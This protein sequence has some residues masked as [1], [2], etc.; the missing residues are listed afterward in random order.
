MTWQC[1]YWCQCEH[2]TKVMEWLHDEWCYPFQEIGLS[3][4]CQTLSPY[5]ETMK[6]IRCKFEFSLID[7]ANLSL[8]GARSALVPQTSQMW[9]VGY[10]HWCDCQWGQPVNELNHAIILK[11]N[12]YALCFCWWCLH[13]YLI[14]Y[15]CHNGVTD[16]TL[17]WCE[18]WLVWWSHHIM[19]CVY[20]GA[21]S[22]IR[23]MSG[24]Q[25][26]ALGAHT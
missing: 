25:D 18:H 6:M 3:D 15:T 12:A 19:Y 7:S 26:Q 22:N 10:P 23:N 4:Q 21:Q 1:G 5:N 9:P 2:Y 11:Y 13:L 17:A 8:R 14:I 20:T 24:R 16:H